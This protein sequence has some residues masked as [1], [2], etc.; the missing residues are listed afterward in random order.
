[1]PYSI[2]ANDPVPAGAQAIGIAIPICRY[3][4]PVKNRL[5]ASSVV[6]ET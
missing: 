3:R 2:D 4:L 5:N 6:V 1:M